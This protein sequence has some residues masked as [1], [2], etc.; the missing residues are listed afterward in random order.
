MNDFTFSHH[1]AQ[2]QLGLETCK[3]LTDLTWYKN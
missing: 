1:F 3:E 2:E